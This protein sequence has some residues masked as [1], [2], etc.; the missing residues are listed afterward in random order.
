MMTLSTGQPSTLGSYLDMCDLVFGLDSKQSK[1]IMEEIAK[2]PNGKN[3]EVIAAESQMM[4]L[5]L[6]LK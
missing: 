3:E 5:L 2:T 1:F 4:Y 6:S